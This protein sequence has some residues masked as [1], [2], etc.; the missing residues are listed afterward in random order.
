[1]RIR[2]ASI[3]LATVCVAVVASTQV[4]Y[5]PDGVLDPDPERAAQRAKWYSEELTRFKEPSLLESEVAASVES[6]RFLWL[7]SSRADMCIR[8]D[9][10][11]DGTARVT[12]KIAKEKAGPG[13]KSNRVTYVTKEQT[14]SF[15]GILDQTGFWRIS[16][17]D[18]YRGLDGSDW[19][20]EGT[21]R[22]TYHVVDR[23]TPK[24]ESVRAIGFAMLND[25]ANLD[26]SHK[27]G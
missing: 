14:D 25:L 4:K 24:D 16:T 6:Y 20:I 5:F 21:K 3:L 10:N 13:K 26:I 23:W 8:L 17:F 22:G 9:V 19:I 2:C 11:S 7:R 27:A 18:S 1:M 15:L 12:T